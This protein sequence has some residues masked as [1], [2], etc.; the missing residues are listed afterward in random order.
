MSAVALPVPDPATRVPS[1]PSMPSVEPVVRSLTVLYDADCP[2]CRWVRGWLEEQ[3]QIVPLRWLPCGSA[4]A[5]A[6][7]PHLDHDRT[8]EEI[9]VIADSGEVWTAEGAW[10]A[11][12]WATVTYRDLA[13]WLSHP[14]R[15]QSAR[16]AALA[17]ASRFRRTPPPTCPVPGPG[18]GPRWVPS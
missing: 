1:M 8:Q 18:I 17:A 4:Q 6:A 3:P 14:K 13:Y 5:R 10:I 7:L 15:R 11:C 2:L 16:S 9:T 12:L